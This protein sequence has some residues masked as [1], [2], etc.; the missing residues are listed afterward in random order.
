MALCLEKNPA[1][2]PQTVQE[3]LDCLDGK[4]QPSTLNQERQERRRREAEAQR[5]REEAER[6]RVQ[7]EQEER[8]A[9]EQRAQEQ[10]QRE[11]EAQRQREAEDRQHRIDQIEHMKDED[12]AATIHM[13]ELFLKSGAAQYQERALRLSEELRGKLCQITEL[14]AAANKASTAGDLAQ[15]L[16]QWKNI[17]ALVPRYQTA[18]A[19]ISNVEAILSSFREQQA[20]ALDAMEKARFDDADQG[21]QQCLQLIPAS[22]EINRNLAL[23]RQRAVQYASCFSKAKAAHK[24]KLLLEAMYAIKCTLTQAPASSEA[25]RFLAELEQKLKCTTALVA[26]TQQCMDSAEFAAAQ[27]RMDQIREVQADHGEIANLQTTMSSRRNSYAQAM[28][29]AIRARGS[30]DLANAARAT[31]LALELCPH[32]KDARLKSGESFHRLE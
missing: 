7:K 14:V 25:H 5:Q 4:L 18:L 28:E 13:L 11:A 2:R 21:F 27:Q 9:Q 22:Q 6:Q 20:R 30:R 15:A 32:S 29:E 3:L 10:R 31:K 26:E 16:K 8:L 23:C 24:D 12:P 19:Q 1:D 17:L